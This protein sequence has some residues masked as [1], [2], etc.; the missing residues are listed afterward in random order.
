MV[1]F[2]LY[3]HLHLSAVIVAW[4]RISIY[5]LLSVSNNTLK[6]GTSDFTKLYP[7]KETA[8]WSFSKIMLFHQFHAFRF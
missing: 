6:F 1:T 5:E 2:Y 4:V 3:E 7:G 8:L